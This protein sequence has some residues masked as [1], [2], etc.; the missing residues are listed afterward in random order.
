MATDAG[1]TPLIASES[2]H[3]HWLVCRVG[4]RLCA[5]PL[6]NVVETM[7]PLPV[8]PIAGAPS[9]V[10][11]LCILRG[12]PVP[13]VEV[14]SLLGEQSARPERLVTLKVGSRLV[15]LALGQVVGLRPMAAM[16]DEALPPLLRDAG[17]EI[18]T[19]IA[20]LDAELLLVLNAARV[21]PD[22]L[23]ESIGMEEAAL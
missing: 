22:G 1:D 3:T 7:R 4:P 13:V 2:S 12:A 6:L 18:V 20:T 14:A 10:L 19:A 8:E 5:L 17:G 9:F 11:G 21:V 15:A 23:F 16:S